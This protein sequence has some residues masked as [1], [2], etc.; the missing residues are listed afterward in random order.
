MKAFIALV[1]LVG[2]GM[3]LFSGQL[4]TRLRYGL[5]LGMPAAQIH[6][7]LNRAGR[8]TAHER[9]YVSSGSDGVSLNTIVDSSY[10]LR[11]NHFI[12]GRLLVVYHSTAGITKIRDRWIWRGDF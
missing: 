11:S 7:H 4:M 6:R 2:L 9:T 8:F 3:L 1:T 5:R 10:A 12:L